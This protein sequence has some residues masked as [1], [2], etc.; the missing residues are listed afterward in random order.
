[1]HPGSIPGEASIVMNA[2]ESIHA[3]AALLPRHGGALAAVAHAYGIARRDLLDLSTGINP[4]PWPIPPLPADAFTR[5][6][7][8]EDLA[9]L[10]SAARSAY[11]VAPR[12]NILA[13]PGSDIA[14]RL[15]PTLRPAG[16]VGI[17]SPTYSGH[18][19]AWR[20]AGHRVTEI[21]WSSATGPI[22]EVD[23]I[24]LVSPNNPDGRRLEAG[25]AERLLARLPAHGL[26]LIDEAFA[27]LD[28]KT[29]LAY[30]IDDP[31]LVLLRSF[32]KFYGLAGLRLGFVIG[33]GPLLARFAAL[34]GDWPLSGPAVVTG[35]AALADEA[36]RVA[37]R[38]RLGESRAA[39]DEVLAR[40]GLNVAGGTDLFRFLRDSRARSLHEHLARAGI[41]T[42]IF[43]TMP[44][45]IRI[46][47][48]RAG[49]L[50]RLAAALARW[51]GAAD[52]AGH[53]PML[54]DS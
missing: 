9:A 34:M 32:G 49:E 24:V 22:A 53:R 43:Q 45:A 1:M 21:A 41:W 16:H 31:R 48:P 19:E 25:G 39:L 2:G 51:S 8:P 52:T 42:R 3:S 29:G 54:S 36:W 23:A 28:E 35:R 20:Q 37:A 15:I 17:L 33:S 18:A 38:Q 11:G 27:D 12:T 13:A 40:H 50:P 44:D 26:L 6:P 14:L 7:D 10:I 30:R 5:L 46:G 47:L 4:E